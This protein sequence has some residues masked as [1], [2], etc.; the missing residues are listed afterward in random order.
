[1]LPEI[2]WCVSLPTI[3][4]DKNSEDALKVIEKIDLEFLPV[5]DKDSGKFLG[6]VSRETI[7]RKY[8]NELF[9]QQSEHDLA[10]G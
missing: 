5:L 10:L 4:N 9:I 2:L 8:Q 1:M 3:S 6:I 7:L